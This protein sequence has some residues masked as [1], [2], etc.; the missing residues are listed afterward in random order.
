MSSSRPLK[1]FVA[2]IA[3]AGLVVASLLA[4]NTSAAYADSLPVDSSEPATVTAD[5]LPTVQINGVAWSQVVVGTTVYVAGSFTTARPAGA[6]AG[7]NTTPR[8][9]L[10]AYDIT[11]G[12]LIDTWAP[13]VNAQ[14]LAI[15]ASPDGSTIY[16]GGGFTQANGVTRS[17][18][19]AFNATTGTL[20]ANFKP[21]AQTTVRAITV[22]PSTVYYGGDFTTVDGLAR[23]YVAANDVTTGALLPFNPNADAAVLALTLNNSG[24]KLVIGGRYAHMGG[25]SWLGLSAVDPTS[26]A[27]QPWAATSTVHNAGVSAAFLSLTADADGVYGTGYTYGGGGNFEGT[28]RA[29]GETGAIT[30]IEDCHGDTYSV[31]ATTSNVYV[32]SHEHYCG[33]IGGFW[34]TTPNWDHFNSTAFT[35]TVTGTITKDNMGYANFAGNPHPGLLSWFPRW[36]A[37]TYTGQGQATWSVSGT[38]NGDYIVYGGE[39]PTVNST[40]QQGLVRFAKTSAATNK[41][42]PLASTAGQYWSTQSF[43]VSAQSLTAGTAH[44]SW[45]STMDRDNRHL[46][47]KVYRNY[48][49]VNGTPVCTVVADNYFWQPKTMGCDDTGQTPGSSVKYRV[50]AFDDL[51]NRGSTADVTVTIAAS[52]YSTTYADAVRADQPT[53]YWRMDE[54]SGNT[55]AVDLVGNDDMLAFAGVTRGTAGALLNEADT[56]SS[57]SGT[58]SGLTYGQD[59][60]QAPNTFT[61]AAWIKTN[62]TKGGA[63]MSFGNPLNGSSGRSD[64]VVYMDNTGRI[65]FGVNNGANQTVNTTATFN[66]NQWHQVVASMGPLGMRLF[67]D[68]KILASRS[69]VTTGSTFDGDWRVGHATLSSWAAAPSSTALFGSVDEVAVYPTAL[70]A[71]RVAAHYVA[72]GRTSSVPLRPADT[73]GQSVYDF[74]PSLYWRLD[75]SAGTTVADSG[76]WGNAGSI[77]S[78][79][80]LGQPGGIFGYPGTAARFNGTNGL[81]VAGTSAVN[82]TTYSVSTW[83]NTTS[84]TGGKLIGFGNASAGISV[85]SDRHIFLRNDGRLDFGAGADVVSPLA[86]NNG[87]WHLAVG[88]QGP[89]GMKLYVDGQLVGTSASTTAQNYTGWW[90]VGGDKV[91]SGATSNYLNGTLDESAVFSTPLSAAQVTALW[92]AGSAPPANQ[93]PTAAFTSTSTGL[94]ATFDA[95]T[96][97]DADGTVAGQAW[98]FGDGTTDTGALANHTYAVDG[99]YQVKLTVT[100]DDGATGSVTNPVTVARP[101]NVPP[102]A[103][104]TTSTAKLVLAADASGSSDSD[105]TIAGYAWD[106]GDGTTGTGKTVSHPYGTAGSYPVSLTVTDDR[107]GTNTVTQAVTAVAN[108]APS[109]AFT[110]SVTK[111]AVSVDATTSSDSDGTIAGYAWDFGDGTTGTG[112]TAAHTYLA[113]GPYTVALT[114]TDNDGSTDSVTHAVTAV[115]NAAPSAAFTTSVTKL[116]LSVDASTSSDGDGTIAGYAWDFGDGTTGTGKTTTHTYLAAGPYTVA[117]TVTDNDGST[118]STT[119]AV[120]AVANAAPV[121]AFT[122][123]TA[124]LTASLDA[125]GSSDSDGTISG[126]AWNY[127][128]GTTGTGKTPTHPYLTANT[129]TVT[130]TVTD[131]DGATTVVT[132]PVT[133]TAPASGVLA[134]DTFTRTLASGWGIADT[135]GAWTLSGAASLFAVNGGVGTM[136]VGAGKGPLAHLAG[137]SSLNTDLSADV[138]LDKLPD[139]GSFYVGLTGRGNASDSYRGSALIAANG[140]VRVNVTKVVAGVETSVSTT[141]TVSGLTVTAGSTL[142]LRMQVTGTGTTTIKVRAWSGATEPGTWQVTTTDTT[143][144]LQNPG[145]VGIRGYMSASTTNGPVSLKLDKIVATTVN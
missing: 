45:S 78:G 23:G 68:G 38:A 67:V 52:A 8:A 53:G 87:A 123:T 27:V 89:G 122:S 134:S 3:S 132:H 14:A 107:G 85:K 82:P 39:F 126:Y 54:A 71:G 17:R 64:R 98:D 112:Q 108:A 90:R 46:T 92:S 86:Y 18:I 139:V 59:T 127:G 70:S 12:N 79:V 19:A 125:S 91:G 76:P 113:A 35:K 26:G 100:D 66:N 84:T 119:H 6:A 9:N 60:K 49:T 88:T 94:T 20:V 4:I 63:I 104:F 93:A 144:S 81:V 29:D 24:S 145:G 80:T 137:V 33:N 96:S 7:V 74:E 41:V 51:G 135:G 34:Q 30:W 28:F 25:L 102:V 21:S 5:P 61:E 77:K 50:I 10:L 111:L 120:T 22:T 142:H 115:A 141:V 47:Y 124:D 129:Y 57:L 109:A 95:S 37:G 118:D 83:F 140:G 133:V 73:Y 44:I 62:T 97:S 15:A 116:V 31:F 16:V 110:T 65:W 43:H 103:A 131:N 48:V 69:D 1:R 58:T 72:S 32:A 130:L 99:T 13:T 105:G 55:S 40:S 138:S 2:G 36:V 101:A 106:F 143:A 128:D 75:E 117:L 42:G 11:T 114:V 56:A 136:S 121:A